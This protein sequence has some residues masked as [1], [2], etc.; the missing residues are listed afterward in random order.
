M[1]FEIEKP[2]REPRFLY[3]KQHLDTEEVIPQ[4]AT[5]SFF[6]S[7]TRAQQRTAFTLFLFKKLRSSIEENYQL[8][9]ST[10]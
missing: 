4:Q 2:M 5:S 8:C 6:Y 7:T 9:Q 10:M 3:F 1:L